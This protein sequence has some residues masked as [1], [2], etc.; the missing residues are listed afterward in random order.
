MCNMIS[1]IIIDDE[2]LAVSL[3]ESYTAECPLT[4]LKGKFTNPFDALQFLENNKTDLIF[5]DVQMPELTGIQFMKILNSK[6]DFILT[7]AYPDYAVN[8][9][10]MNVVDYLLKPIS[11]ERFTRAVNKAR[12]KLF[13]QTAAQKTDQPVDYLLVKSDYKQVKVHFDDIRYLEGLRDY[14]AIHT[15]QQKLLTL[16]SLKSFEESLPRNFIRVH[17]SY[18]V[19]TDEISSIRNN[20]LS[21]NKKDIPIGAVYAHN[22]KS[23]KQ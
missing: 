6:S 8:A 2:P 19:N 10:D 20:M 7:T 21:L 1:C 13:A 3:L 5:L 15:R 11:F 18:I 9:F 23:F 16:Q 17:K 22:L 14:V 12:E 4:T